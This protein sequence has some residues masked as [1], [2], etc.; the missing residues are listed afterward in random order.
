MAVLVVVLA[1]AG[2]ALGLA[3]ILAFI[4]LLA[5]TGRS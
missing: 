1:V 2:V 5:G 4:V 3:A